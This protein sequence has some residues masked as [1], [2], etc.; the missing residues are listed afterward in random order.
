[1]MIRDFWPADRINFCMDGQ[2][3][4]FENKQENKSETKM[5]A[6]ILKQDP[7]MQK[8]RENYF[9]MTTQNM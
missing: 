2:Q 6:R 5:S 4:C 9:D 3:I 7:N 8:I 1:M